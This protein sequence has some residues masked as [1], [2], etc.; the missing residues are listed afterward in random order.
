LP[1]L[2]PFLQDGTRQR[3]WSVAVAAVVFRHAGVGPEPPRRPVVDDVAW[4]AAARGGVGT[5][6]IGLL[7]DEERR[8]PVREGEVAAAPEDG[9]PAEF[10]VEVGRFQSVPAA[11]ELIPVG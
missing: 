7:R 10:I 3:L 8:V 9:A 11:S 4:P 2:G 1:G 5:R 6:R